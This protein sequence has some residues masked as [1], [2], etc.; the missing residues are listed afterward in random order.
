M[1][2]AFAAAGIGQTYLERI[3]GLGYLETQHK[4]QVHFLM[5]LGTGL[6]FTLGVALYLYDFFFL[7]PKR[8]PRREAWPAGEPT[9]AGA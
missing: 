7:A 2:M 5:V 3:L 8:Q 6:L 9:E 1:T 4:I